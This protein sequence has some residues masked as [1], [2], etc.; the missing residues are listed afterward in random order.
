M[1]PVK[2]NKCFSDFHVLWNFPNGETEI[3]PISLLYFPDLDTG[4]CTVT[5][6]YNL[7]IH[8]NSSPAP[9]QHGLDRWVE[10]GECV[11]C[12][13]PRLWSQEWA[14]WYANP[15]TIFWFNPH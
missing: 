9:V 12:S 2:E 13:A 3:I 7:Q 6:E 4:N 10:E 1:V 5:D 15:G 8:N 11:G 14:G